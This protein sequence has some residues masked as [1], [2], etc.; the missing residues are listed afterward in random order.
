MQEAIRL[1]VPI[2]VDAKVGDNWGEMGKV[3]SYKV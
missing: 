2:T 1:S 3:E